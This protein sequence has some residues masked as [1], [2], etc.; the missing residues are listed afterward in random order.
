MIEEYSEP[1]LLTVKQ[2]AEKLGFEEYQIYYYA[3]HGILTPCRFRRKIMF[4]WET[5]LKDLEEMERNERN[6]KR[7]KYRLNVL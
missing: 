4:R 6:K 2:I 5:I 7:K 3:K 1:E